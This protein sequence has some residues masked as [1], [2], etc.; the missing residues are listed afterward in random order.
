LLALE[1]DPA[2]RERARLVL[3]GDGPLRSECA[4]LLRDAGCED[5]A[6]FA[7]ERSDVPDVMRGL[8]CFVLPSLVEGISNTILE[9]MSSGLP[10]LATEVGG[11][12]DLVTEGVTGHLV[13]AGDVGAMAERILRL[14]TEPGRAREL[15]RAGR[16]AVE[17]RFSLAAMVAAYEGLYDQVLGRAPRE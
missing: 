5:L 14:A 2:L 9:A 3:V 1:H 6:W 8:D 4:G 15:G 16:T 12:A 17:Q 13:P 7:G 11:N 10:V